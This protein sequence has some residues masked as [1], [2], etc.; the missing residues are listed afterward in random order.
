M[1]DGDNVLIRQKMVEAESL[2]SQ[3]V[4]SENERPA[5]V[6]V[7]TSDE[8][9]ELMEEPLSPRSTPAGKRVPL[10]E[11]R[12]LYNLGLVDVKTGS[13]RTLAEGFRSGML[14]PTH[15]GSKVAVL[16]VSSVDDLTRRRTHELYLVD[17]VTQSC[18][19]LSA[20]I[21]PPEAAQSLSWSPDDSKFALISDGDLFVY[22]LATGR[23]ERHTEGLQLDYKA[24]EPPV[25]NRKGSHIYYTSHGQLYRLGI[26]DNQV[27]VISEGLQKTVVSVIYRNG[28]Q[29]IDDR[30]G[31]VVQTLDARS[32]HQ[33]MYRLGVDGNVTCLFEEDVH[34][35]GLSI[36]DIQLAHYTD[37]T[38]D[39]SRVAY[40][41]QRADMPPDIWLAD[42]AF[43]NRRRVTVINP[44]LRSSFGR[45]EFIDYQ[46]T[47]GEQR[48][49][50]LLRPPAAVAKPPYPVIVSVYPRWHHHEKQNLFGGGISAEGNSQL[51]STRGYAVLW[52]DMTDCRDEFMEDVAAFVLPA[53]DEVVEMGLADPTRLGVIGHSAGGF[54]VN[55][56]V[57]QTDRF[58]AAISM[59]GGSDMISEYGYMWSDGSVYRQKEQ[60]QSYGGAPW[61][62]PQTYLDNSPL[63]YV[64]D[65]RTPILF[66]HGENDDASGW[67]NA[68]EM[69]AAL[70]RLGKESEFALYRTESHIPMDW[71]PVNRIDLWNRILDWFHRHLRR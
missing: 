4:H 68:A 65:V 52:P 16:S 36:R 5:D 17:V 18:E 49:C 24:C 51:Y 53:I 61:E 67:H 64:S 44:G 56:L 41:I 43:E 9:S 31:I 38:S 42:A 7:F 39:D 62:V 50:M 21:H 11:D 23:L 40:I 33:G 59:A 1:P 20:D 45:A 6:E 10:F 27:Q 12:H 34:I 71:S 19:L 15:D 35:G 14:V 70:R 8:I 28:I 63:M 22:G 54:A 46:L 30:R 48:K 66:I 32:G 13:L 69:F 60:E 26:L 2:P 57:T 55:A 37:C 47:N 3:N 25:W 29:M 58:A